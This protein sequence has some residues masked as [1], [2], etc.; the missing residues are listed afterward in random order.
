MS[1]NSI[2]NKPT[3]DLLVACP[4]IK[5]D[6][7]YRTFGEVWTKLNEVTDVQM[8]CRRIHNALIEYIRKS[9]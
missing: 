3:E 2:S 5:K 8:E 9:Q 7:N 4:L 6:G 1:T